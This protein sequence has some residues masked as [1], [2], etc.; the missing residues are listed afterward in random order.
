MRARVLLA[1]TVALVTGLPVAAHGQDDIAAGPYRDACLR[2]AGSDGGTA[3]DVAQDVKDGTAS[4]LGPG[5]HCRTRAAAI[6]VTPTNDLTDVAETGW[7]RVEF[8]D[9]GRTLDV[10]FSGIEDC[11]GLDR[12][13]VTTSAEGLDVRVFTGRIPSAG[14]C[15]YATRNYVT[16]VQLDDFEVTGASGGA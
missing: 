4:V 11:F 2:V 1:C 3:A 12:V 5:E 13:D 15:R 9:D 16:T 10:Y 6:A 14:V 7:D 8:R